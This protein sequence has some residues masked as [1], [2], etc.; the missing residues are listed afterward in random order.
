MKPL[1]RL[2]EER[3]YPQIEA[4]FQQIHRL[5]TAW[6]PDIYKPLE[7][8]LSHADFLAHLQRGEALVA[9]L[10]GEIVGVAIY[11]TRQIAGA[12]VVTRKVLFVDSIGVKEGYRGQGIGH[13]LLDRIRRICEEGQYDGLELQVNARNLA[14]RQ[15]Y[16]AYGF[17]E[18]SVNL[19]LLPLGE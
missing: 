2:A 13:F 6:R 17:T 10:D 1:I 14:A 18:K 5:H 3:D 12:P 4:I 16:A 15:M 8:V 19:E 9:E 7:P 11:V